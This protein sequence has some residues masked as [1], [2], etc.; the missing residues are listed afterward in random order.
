MHLFLCLKVTSRTIRI[1]IARHTCFTL[2]NFTKRKTCICEC[3][4][5][6]PRY[7]NIWQSMHF[8]FCL[9]PWTTNEFFEVGRKFIGVIFWKKMKKVTK[10]HL[11]LH[12]VQSSNLSPNWHTRF[13]NKKASYVPSTRLLRFLKNSNARRELLDVNYGN[14]NFLKFLWRFWPKK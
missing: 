5:A 4:G 10:C 14:K 6:T 1:R 2:V 8:L 13:F 9:F 12:F 11:C 3:V 7:G